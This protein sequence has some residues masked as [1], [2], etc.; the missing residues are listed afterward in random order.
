MPAPQARIVV[1]THRWI[2][3]QQDLEL[4]NSWDGELAAEIQEGMLQAIA[5]VER[6]MCAAAVSHTGGTVN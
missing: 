3:L 2:R 6:Q 4:A 1:L 5:M